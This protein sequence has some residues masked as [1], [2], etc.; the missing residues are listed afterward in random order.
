MSFPSVVGVCWK[1][2]DLDSTVDP[3]TGEVLPGRDVSGVSPAD[4]AALEWALR[5]GAGWGC[6]VVVVAG[7][8]SGCEP[9]LRAALA[10]GASRAVRVPIAPGSPSAVVAARLAPVLRAA[11]AVAVVCGDA[12]LDRGSGSV[13]AFLAGELR[14]AQALGLVDLSLEPGDRTLL[15]DRRLD[16]G[17][18]ERLRVREPFVISVE[19]GTAR[20]RRAFLPAL[21]ASRQSE[22]EVAEAG[23]EPDVGGSSED[24]PGHLRTD[25]VKIVGIEPFRPRARVVAPP[26]ASLG[27][28]ERVLALSGAQLGRQPPRTLTLGPDEAAAALLQALDDWGELP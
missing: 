12:S 26:P 25:A 7:G 6:P 20:L 18:R 19:A 13:P 22:P 11:G 16:R 9:A 5:I 2:V 24:R 3:L 8:D 10:A 21:L 28:R 15:V 1:V 23:G 17:R 14:A 4:E 27:P